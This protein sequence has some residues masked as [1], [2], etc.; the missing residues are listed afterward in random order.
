MASAHLAG[1]VTV[2]VS[3]AAVSMEVASMEASA[4]TVEAVF[5]ATD[6]TLTSGTC[7]FG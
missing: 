1:A 4:S 2:G 7:C 3:R 5:G 6:A